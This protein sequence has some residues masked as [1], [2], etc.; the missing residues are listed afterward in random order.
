MGER[1][2]DVLYRLARE[3]Y[4]WS[5]VARTLADELNAL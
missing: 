2:K 4:D 5:S 3:R 1:Y